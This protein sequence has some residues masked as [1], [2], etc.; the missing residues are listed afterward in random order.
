MFRSYSFLLLVL[1]F[2]AVFLVLDHA[3]EE[4]AGAEN[5]NPVCGDIIVSY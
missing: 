5:V 1:V 2:D 3:G 4:L